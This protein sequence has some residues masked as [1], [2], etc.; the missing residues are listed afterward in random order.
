[1]S[2]DPAFL[3]YAGDYLKDTQCLSES[4]QVA[5]DRIMCE[6][7][8]NICISQPQLN[9]F[10]K[11]LNPEQKSE[12]LHVL[13]KVPGGFQI[14]WVAISLEKR[15]NYSDS[16]R[17]NRE[18]KS[19]HIKDISKSYV[20]HMENGDVN[21]NV[22]EDK[23]KGAEKNFSLPD[24]AGDE[25]HFPVDT[26]NIRTAWAKWKEFRFK[27]HGKKYPIFGEQAALKQFEGMTEQDILNTIFKAIE[28]NWFNLYPDRNGNKNGTANR[29]GV[30][31]NA[32]LE[33]IANHI[34]GGQ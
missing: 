4:V 18:G 11:R 27:S 33:H 1:M 22:I 31:V 5:Y 28:S 25:I 17:K 26:Q 7:M 30:D 20:P 8:R 32:A 13:K 34:K 24:V 12:L 19:N 15:R 10:T 3:F 29:K 16:R 14:E 21:E 2:S 23:L 9:F 6:H